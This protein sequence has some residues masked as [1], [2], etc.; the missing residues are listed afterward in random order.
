MDYHNI[1]VPSFF[2]EFVENDFSTIE[3]QSL[4]SLKKLNE[5]NN[6]CEE[7]KYLLGQINFDDKDMGFI[8]NNLEFKEDGYNRKEL[9]GSFNIKLYKYLDDD[10]NFLLRLIKTTECDEYYKSENKIPDSVTFAEL[11][12]ERD[13][14]EKGNPLW[15]IINK[16]ITDHKF[17]KEDFIP[18]TKLICL[19]IHNDEIIGFLIKINKNENIFP[20]FKITDQFFIFNSVGDHVRYNNIDRTI[21]TVHIPIISFCVDAYT[22]VKKSKLF[23][24]MN[25]LENSDKKDIVEWIVR[26]YRDM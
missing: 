6:I 16:K 2:Q 8:T 18:I 13:L 1:Y 10:D 21:G 4:Y 5:D 12:T 23:E 19:I 11:H 15:I 24:R 9:K 22:I 7:T 26:S 14:S 17:K 3:N 20:A 25:W